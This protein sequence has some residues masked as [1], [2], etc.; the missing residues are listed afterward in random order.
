MVKR[1]GKLKDA[2]S[3]PA[4]QL[5]CLCV[6][7]CKWAQIFPYKLASHCA[8]MLAEC[9]RLLGQLRKTLLFTAKA[10]ASFMLMC[11]GSC[12][13]LLFHKD[14]AKVITEAADWVSCVHER[15]TEFGA[16]RQAA[17]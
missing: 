5:C 6:R 4:L 14:N 7:N 3:P 10:L 9:K 2:L 17:L 16:L 15:N 12:D 8:S 1:E 11:V 13:H